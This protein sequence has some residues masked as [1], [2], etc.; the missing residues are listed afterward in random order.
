[1]DSG[2]KKNPGQA[3]GGYGGDRQTSVD[4][5]ITQSLFDVNSGN[6]FY[7]DIALPLIR[8]C[9]HQA[10]DAAQAVRAYE[11]AE[12]LAAESRLV[13]EQVARQ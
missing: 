8:I 7:Q 3:T 11:L 9:Q 2:Y 6:M 5:N 4:Q 10:E 13:R 12:W 1:M